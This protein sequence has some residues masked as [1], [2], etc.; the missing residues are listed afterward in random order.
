MVYKMKASTK[1]CQ[2]QQVRYQLRAQPHL[3]VR[4]MAIPLIKFQGEDC[5]K[6]AAHLF[7]LLLMWNKAMEVISG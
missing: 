6:Y 5:I 2:L 7:W 1:L 3:K 4:Q